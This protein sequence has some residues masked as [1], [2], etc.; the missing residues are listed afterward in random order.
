LGGYAGITRG[1]PILT[2]STADSQFFPGRNNQ[3]WWNQ[4]AGHF[5]GNDNPLV[6]VAPYG[7]QFPAISYNDFFTFDLRGLPAG[8]RVTSARLNLERGGDTGASVTFYDVSTD[9]AH[10]SLG[11]GPDPSVFDDLGSGRIYGALGTGGGNPSDVLSVDLDSAAIDDINASA[12]GFFSVGGHADGGYVFAGNDQGVHTLSLEV[13][14]APEPAAVLVAISALAVLH[15]R[16]SRG[17]RRAFADA[18]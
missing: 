7:S 6:G 5:A 3:G 2:F 17:N 10:L 13:V 11:Q 8:L 18:Q 4:V 12:G 1:L 15:R 9:A 16:R 14:A